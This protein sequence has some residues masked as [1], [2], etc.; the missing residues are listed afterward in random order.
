MFRRLSFAPLLREQ[1]NNDIVRVD[2][3]SEIINRS[4]LNRAHCRGDI[5]IGSYND[6][7][8]VGSALLQCCDNVQ[9]VAVAETQVNDGKG[10]RMPL[11]SRQS[12]AGRVGGRHLEP[13]YGQSLSEPLTK[14]CIIL[15]QQAESGRLNQIP[16]RHGR[17]DLSKSIVPL[18]RFRVLR[19]DTLSWP[20]LRRGD[21]YLH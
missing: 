1:H 8:D 18:W 21:V 19:F 11:N 17:V 10:R 4:D 20:M 9:T 5:A 16:I 12:V 6:G 3:L 2:R 7:A 15:H 14:R 13:S